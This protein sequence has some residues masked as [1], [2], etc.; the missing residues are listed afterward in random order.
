MN[1]DC[2][3]EYRPSGLILTIART[4]LV[5]VVN[6]VNVSSPCERE[7][8]EARIEQEKRDHHGEGL[9]RDEADEGEPERGGS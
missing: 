1:A 2:A 5:Y 4:T 9:D 7:A 3:H 8:R 6:M